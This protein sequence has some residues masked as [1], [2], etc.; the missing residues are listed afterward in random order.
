MSWQYICVDWNESIVAHFPPNLSQ[1]VAQ[2]VNDTE[3]VNKNRRQTFAD[4]M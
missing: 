1:C 3:D 2:N 4:I